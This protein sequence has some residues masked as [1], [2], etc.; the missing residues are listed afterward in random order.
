MPELEPVFEGYLAQL[1]VLLLLHFHLHLPPHNVVLHHIGELMSVVDN[2]QLGEKS[3]DW[4][5]DNG[6]ISQK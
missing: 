5:K 3:Q 1:A 6:R 4:I 2:S